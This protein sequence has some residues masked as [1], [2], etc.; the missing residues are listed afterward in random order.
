MHK[1]QCLQFAKNFLAGCKK[2]TLTSLAEHSYWRD[3]KKDQL[4]VSY[5]HHLVDLS[6]KH[7]NKDTLA[8]SYLNALVSDN[9]KTIADAK[10]ALK[11]QIEAT[12]KANQIKRLIESQD[13]RQVHFKFDPLQ[14]Y[15][16]TRFARDMDLL[17]EG[18]LE[19][20]RIDDKE[21]YD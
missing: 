1:I 8:K 13:K 15:M 17:L 3:T 5:K 11:K 21:K 9:T 20:K 4:E 16:Q 2:G 14:A 18:T 6:C 7:S 12:K 10:V 19:E